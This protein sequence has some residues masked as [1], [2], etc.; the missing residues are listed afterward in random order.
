MNTDIIAEKLIAVNNNA[1]LTITAESNST[2]TYRLQS[3]LHLVDN[4]STLCY[5]A[6]IMKDQLFVFS[7]FFNESNGA[8]HAQVVRIA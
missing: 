8:G 5:D 7:F 6:R 3:Y 4:N 2:D 1:F